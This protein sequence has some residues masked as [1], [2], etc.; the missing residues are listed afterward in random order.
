MRLWKSERPI[1]AAVDA[2]KQARALEGLASSLQTGTVQIRQ[3]TGLPHDRFSYL[4]R[5]G[6]LVIGHVVNSW[7]PYDLVPAITERCVETNAHEAMVVSDRPTLCR[8]HRRQ[9]SSCESQPMR[10]KVRSRHRNAVVRMARTITNA[11]RIGPK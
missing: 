10:F 4:D 7:T 1:S 6:K 11:G 9:R 2:L 8:R 3:R 5:R